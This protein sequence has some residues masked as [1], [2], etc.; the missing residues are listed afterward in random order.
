[1]QI[2]VIDVGTPNSRTS[3]TGRQ[4]Q[5]IELM[6]KDSTGKPNSKKIMSFNSD[7]YK[8]VQGLQRGAVVFV[9]R[10]KNDKTG[11]WDWVSIGEGGEVMTEAAQPRQAASAAPATRVTGSNYETKEERAARQVLIVKQSSL[12]TAVA[13][14]AVGAKSAPSASDVI[15]YAKQLEEYVMGTSIEHIASD[16]VE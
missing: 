2:T 13:A 10:V 12:S 4:F 5:E 9:Q 8:A 15:A 14:L 16:I 7:L 11:Y 3:S 6:F 1:M